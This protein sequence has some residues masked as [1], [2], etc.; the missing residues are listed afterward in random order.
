MLPEAERAGYPP[1]QLAAE[2][3]VG[4]D[5]ALYVDDPASPIVMLGDSFTG[6]FQFEDCKHAGL[7]A[8]L[9]KELGLP[10]DLVMAQGSGPRIRGQLA[11]RGPEGLAQKRLV[12]WTMVSRDLHN[13]WANW[14]LIELP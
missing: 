3:V 11:R 1:M 5:G 13:Y 7:S 8:H 10:I 12:I 14:D 4:A 2:Q 9:A 6:V